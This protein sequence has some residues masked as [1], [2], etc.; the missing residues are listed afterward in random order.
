VEDKIPGGL[1]DHKS[2]KDFNPR[3][4]AKGM[5]VEREHTSSD[6]IAKEIARD[7]LTEDPAYYDKLEKIEKKVELSYMDRQRGVVRAMADKNLGGIIG[8]NNTDYIKGNLKKQLQ[9][10]AIGGAGGAALGALA[11]LASKGEV[12]PEAGA[13]IGGLGGAILGQSHGAYRHN[14]EYLAD[15]GITKKYLGLDH[16]FSPE[17]RKKYIDKYKQGTMSDKIPGGLADHKS[18][19]DF[20]PRALAKGMKVEREHTSSDDIAKEIARDHLTEDPA[21]YDKLEKIEKKA[22]WQSF[23]KQALLAGAAGKLMGKAQRLPVKALAASKLLV[24][25]V[26]NKVNAGVSAVKNQAAKTRKEFSVMQQRALGPKGRKAA[27]QQVAA[28]QQ[29]AA[30]KPAGPGALS[31]ARTLAT[32]GATAGGVGMYYGLKDTPQYEQSRP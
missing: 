11:T 23:E 25:P 6:D 7:H 2:D 15:K 9:H 1:A 27:K 3:A 17:A 14:S 10:G 24:Q 29:A 26:V 22:F 19:K 28:K 32:L 8:I 4:L 5:K 16:E 12:T 18:D 13:A 31:K 21:Y 30:A 20:N